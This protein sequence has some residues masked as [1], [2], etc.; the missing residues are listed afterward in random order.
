MKCS[1]FALLIAVG[2]LLPASAQQPSSPLTQV[3][4]LGTGIPVADPDRSGP[5]VA[6]V[7]NGHA[8]LVD[9]GP[10]VIRRA[11]AAAR[12]GVSGLEMPNLRT[13]FITHLH[14]DHTLGLPDLIFTPWVLGRTDHLTAY[15][16]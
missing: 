13:V 2:A 10:G 3:V 14:S 15:G 16:P 4:M 9:C 12:N 7:V 1:V 11:A 6:I 5:A 8:Y